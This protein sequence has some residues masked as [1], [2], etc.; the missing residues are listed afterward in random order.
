MS[1]SHN[2]VSQLY[3][4]FN[5]HPSKNL[6][7]QYCHFVCCFVPFTI[8]LS[9]IVLLNKIKTTTFYQSSTLRVLHPFNNLTLLV[10]KVVES[11]RPDHE[12]LIMRDLDKILYSIPRK[13]EFKD[14]RKQFVYIFSQASSSSGM[15]SW[16]LLWLFLTFID[17]ILRSMNKATSTTVR[18]EID[19]QV[20]LQVLYSFDFGR[21]DKF[22]SWVQKCFL[23]KCLSI[24]LSPSGIS[25]KL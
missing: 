23:L 20:V 16:S 1:P 21:N 12:I 7:Q 25:W 2:Q 10:K 13:L 24:T 11:S 19:R 17:A 8:S 22:W 14:G 5:I 15:I 9:G 4:S 6:K 3:P 18:I